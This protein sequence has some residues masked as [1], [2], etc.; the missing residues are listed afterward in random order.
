MFIGWLVAMF[1]GGAPQQDKIDDG[2][3]G[4]MIRA[5]YLFHFATS[6][7]WPEKY[8]SGTF[9]IGVYGSA[10]VFKELVD[11]YSMK[12]IG[13]QALEIVEMKDDSDFK[14]VHI[15]FVDRNKT[16]K[17]EGVRTKVQGAPVMIVGD[18]EG[19][20]SKGAVINFKIVNASIRYELN[21]EEAKKKELII[22]S[23]I[24]QWAVN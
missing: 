20:L 11:K 12:P 6:N 18:M 14:G 5:N 21:V 10:N 7:N 8:R 2:D 23:K 3:T 24:I 9:R 15:L 13:S 1:F 22:G 17:I 16:S 19:A 4:A